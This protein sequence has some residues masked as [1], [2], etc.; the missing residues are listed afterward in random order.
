[1]NKFLTVTW[2]YW[3]L[4][5]SGIILWLVF[6]IYRPFEP[7]YRGKPLSAWTTIMVNLNSE[8]YDPKRTAF[9]SSNKGAL[10]RRFSI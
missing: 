4:I 9:F 1:M 10:P 8:G 7:H 5:L 3:L 2:K 6:G